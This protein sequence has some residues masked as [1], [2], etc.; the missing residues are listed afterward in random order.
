MRKRQAGHAVTIEAF[1]EWKIRFE[2]EMTAKKIAE[3]GQPNVDSELRV[4]IYLTCRPFPSITPS[5]S[6]HYVVL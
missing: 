6:S 4:S 5:D 1:M 2:A 3:E